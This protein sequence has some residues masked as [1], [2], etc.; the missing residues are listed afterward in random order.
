MC[1]MRR[2]A[3]RRPG[4]HR[5]GSHN[6]RCPGNSWRPALATQSHGPHH[7]AARLES[8]VQWH[9]NCNWRILLMFKRPTGASQPAA[10]ITVQRRT[11]HTSS[12]PTTATSTGLDI[13]TC[14][15]PP[16]WTGLAVRS[17]PVTNAAAIFRSVMQ[18][19]SPAHVSSREPPQTQPGACRADGKG[20]S[21]GD[22]GTEAGLRR[23]GTHQAHGEKTLGHICAGRR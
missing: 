17:L 4:R 3:L 1:L 7:P 5:G 2:Y 13:N 22:P 14:L 10:L 20:L 9:C 8:N 18:P 21:P 11:N 12:V 6:D 19:T 16:R 23:E 15:K